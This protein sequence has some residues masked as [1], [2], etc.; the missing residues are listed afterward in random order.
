VPT[1]QSTRPLRS[2]FAAVLVFLASSLAAQSPQWKLFGT[3]AEGFQALFPSTPEAS[4]NSAPAGASSYELRSYSAQA[5]SS[6][7]YI[8]VCDYGP[9]GRAA[10][11]EKILADA[12]KSAVA[13][14]AAAILS[15]KI[16]TLDAAPASVSHST[17]IDGIE[18]EAANDRMHIVSRIYLADGV[19][20]QI[21][22]TSPLYETFA[23]TTRFL[24][25]F[26]LLPRPAQ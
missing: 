13:H 9:K 6:V 7:L 19:L 20:Y 2:G 16:T 24:D 10:D 3:A 17:T 12:E 22:V 11:P 21:M 1:R 18:F 25:S 23:D 15:E 26:R 4:K 8:G 14:S 5:G